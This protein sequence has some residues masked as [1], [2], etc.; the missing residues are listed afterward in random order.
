MIS[1]KDFQK[2][3]LK[4]AEIKKAEEIEK[5]NK[6]LKL[7]I[8]LGGEKRQLVAGIAKSYQ[9]KELKGKQIVVVTN[10]EP[11]KLMGVESQGMLLAA[12]NENG[13]PIILSPEKKVETGSKVK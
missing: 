9:P 11:K 6:L 1:F 10:L 8:D 2:I 3:D 13:E 4:V 5:A 7:Q 12:T